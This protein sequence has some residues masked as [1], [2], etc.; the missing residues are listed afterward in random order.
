[1]EVSHLS[2][3]FLL[4]FFR[5]APPKTLAKLVKQEIKNTHTEMSDDKKVIV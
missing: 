2:L 1:M 3:S 5:R 4:N